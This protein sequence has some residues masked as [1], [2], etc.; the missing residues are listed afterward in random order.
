MKHPIFLNSIPKS[1]T[2]LLSKALTDVPGIAHS[3][4]H[5]ERKS[6]AKFVDQGVD[7]PVKGREDINLVTDMPWIE[8]LLMTIRPGQFITAHVKYHKSLQDALEKMRFKKLLM[9]RDP[10]DIV[11][12]WADYIA[13]AKDHLLY[14]YFE[15]TDIE[16]RISCGIK[17]IGSAITKTRRQPAISE[18]ISWYLKWKTDGGALL[19]RFEQVIGEQGGGSRQTQHAVLKQV[20]DFLSVACK[21]TD[22]DKICDNLFGGTYTFN[23]GMIGRWKECFT[24]KHKDQF[25]SEAGQFLVEMGYETDLNW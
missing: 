22:I 8:R 5:L 2:H 16:Y 21:K 25:K 9:V 20:L 12:S 24:D 19:V 23:K 3:G 7:F 17:G 15:Q 4:M 6:I 18:L 10:R 11:V 1:G 13:K 14:P